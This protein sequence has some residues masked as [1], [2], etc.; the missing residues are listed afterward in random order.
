MAS[1]RTI[2]KA[3]QKASRDETYILPSIGSIWFTPCETDVSTEGNRASSDAGKVSL[4]LWQFSGSSVCP[5]E[6][7]WSI[8]QLNLSEAQVNSL[9]CTPLHLSEAGEVWP[10]LASGIAGLFL[11]GTAMMLHDLNYFLDVQHDHCSFAMP[12]CNRRTRRN[13]W[14]GF[15]S[16][17]ICRGSGR[18]ESL[19]R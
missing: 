9:C 15:S 7:F 19:T 6:G 4:R 3:C 8:D 12:R 17:R 1:I 2:A 11:P 10:P 16:T 18:Q 13:I 14:L 5:A